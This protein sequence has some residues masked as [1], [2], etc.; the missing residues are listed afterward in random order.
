MIKIIKWIA[1][2]LLIFVIVVLSAYFLLRVTNKIE[3]YNVKTGS[4][5]AKIHIGDYILIFKKGDYNVGDVVT[6]TSDNG[7]ITHRII[8]KEG[9]KVVTKGDA[10]NT[11]DETI[12]EKI[13]IG[14]VVL[15]GGIL[16]I[17]IKYKYVFAGL[18]LSLYLFSCYFEDDKKLENNEKTEDNVEDISLKIEAKD[19]KEN[20]KAKDDL[21][22]DEEKNIYKDTS[23]KE[24]KDNK[25][26]KIKEIDN[27]KKEKSNYIKNNNYNKVKNKEKEKTKKNYKNTIDK[28]NN[29]NKNNNNRNNNKNK[30]NNN[31]NKNKNKNNNNKNNN[32]NKKQ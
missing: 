6:Y 3:I 1:N 18:A 16:N 23:I 21:K 30:N 32:K 19:I 31:R 15:S 7:F 14:K 29:K 8:K 17:V 26:E 27:N 2:L 24:L 10:N 20:D 11:E 22:E 9:D 25:Q 12:S 28:I 4:M 5:E 13:I